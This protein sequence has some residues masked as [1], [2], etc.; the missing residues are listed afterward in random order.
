M[1]KTP[2]GGQA[3]PDSMSSGMTLRDYFAA[4]ALQGYLSGRN[5]AELASD[6]YSVARAC[7]GY[8][9]EMIAERSRMKEQVQE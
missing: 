1:N 2:T 9:D 5:R 6:R 4:K 8:A 3:F 7:Y